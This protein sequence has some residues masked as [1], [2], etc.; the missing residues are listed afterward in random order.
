MIK[1]RLGQK[2][3]RI[4]SQ[5]PDG[6]G[7]VLLNPDD[8][9][10]EMSFE[11]I[12]KMGVE[13]CEYTEDSMIF[14]KWKDLNVHKR[15]LVNKL[16]ETSGYIVLGMEDGDV[17]PEIRDIFASA[18]ATSRL[19]QYITSSFFEDLLPTIFTPEAIENRVWERNVV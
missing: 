12:R 13:K 17:G 10:I 2:Y 4:F 19:L 1:F 18:Y 15:Q 3:Y 6:S 7:L 11:E 14:V 9:K 8:E 5:L 16:I